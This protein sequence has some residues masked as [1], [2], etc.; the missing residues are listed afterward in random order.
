VNFAAGYTVGT[1]EL[2]LGRPREY[3]VELKA[4]F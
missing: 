1:E 3:G 4:R 2:D